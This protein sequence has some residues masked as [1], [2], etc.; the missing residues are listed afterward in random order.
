MKNSI[1]T[2]F[3]AAAA[4]AAL[5]SCAKDADLKVA[6]KAPAKG[7]KVNVI[8]DDVISKTYVEDG[9]VPVVKWSE[10]DQVVF[11]ESMDGEF[12]GY[13]YSDPATLNDG[14]ASFSTIL[15][16][17]AEEGSS[18]KYSAVYP[19]SAFV[20]YSDELY[21]YLPPEQTL[22]GN[23][24][25]ENSDILL[26]TM[27]DKGADRI[28]DGENIQFAFR[29]L[30]TVV[31][32][33]LNGIAP[34]EKIRRI[35]ISAPAYIAGTI[36]YEPQTGGVYPDT[37]FDLVGYDTITLNANDL[38]ATGSDVIWFRVLAERD[39]GEAGDELAFKVST[40]KNFYQKEFETCPVIRFVDGGLTKFSVDLSSSVVDPLEL[41]YLEDF[42]SG[43]PDWTFIDND[44]DGYNWFAVSGT[45][46]V[47]GTGSLLSYSYINNVGAVTPDN[48]AFTPPVQLTE[49]NYL[50]FYVRPSSA[51]WAAEH[52]AVYIAEGS[53]LAEPE[54]LMAE[55]E[56]PNGDYYELADDGM[57]ERFIIQ[58]PEKYNNKSVCIGFRHFNCTDQYYLLLDD[59][60]I[61]EDFPVKPC[62]AEYE[63]YLGEW[64]SGAKVFTV[65]EK[66]NGVSYSIS[67]LAGQNGA[68]IEALYKDNR[69]VL[70]EQ[71]VSSD[72]SGS[73]EV[74]LQGSDGNYPSYPG[75]D[76]LIIF[77]GE[78][79]DEE[80]VINIKSTGN[81]YYMFVTYV[82]QT[83][84]DYE[85][86]SLPSYLIPYVPDTAT[87]L[88]QDD[89][90]NGIDEWTLIDADGDGNNWM[91]KNAKTYSGEYVLISQSYDNT[92]GQLHPDNWAFT[93]PIELTSDNY[94]CFW[95]TAQD[96]N[97]PSEHYAVYI[98]ETAPTAENVDG[99][100]V[101]IPER[102]YPEGDPV[103]NWDNGYQR[104]VVKIPDT[105]DG[106]TVYIGFRHFN[107]TD[108]FW[109]NL[110]DVAIS[111]GNPVA[112]S[113]STTFKPMKAAAPKVQDCS[114]MKADKPM[115]SRAVIAD[116]CRVR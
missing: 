20:E 32:M 62:T 78:Y 4:A 61:T 66:V 1:I 31:R 87:Y 11:F 16:W 85:Y 82:D 34:G 95:I 17:E 90:E 105:Y 84:S 29:R 75:D 69:L 57:Y 28:A 81:K 15:D 2:F 7:I 79:D 38:E 35:E 18:Y 72:A 112:A 21:I 10:G 97:Y 54:V 115:P 36:I 51:S 68:A 55:T 113:A 6:D 71:L 47:S 58:I 108:W 77:K 65:E 114:L 83:R 89:F 80:D 102:I 100:A 43:A 14:K 50:S 12:K 98:T 8:T 5:V 96:Q 74:W 27:V 93:P 42:E 37:A 110:D 19:A 116:I 91:L 109:L 59:V 73:T 104:H 103:A 26:S 44:G 22:N 23:N 94:L 107:C 33:T 52:Y 45:Y 9:E 60:S 76:P 30:G 70:Y 111:E 49:D 63:D 99:C 101:L 46:T 13:A 86:D 3:F 64:A 41:P 56:Y 48:W 106:K 53:P 40:D 88:F 39:W 67:G 25:P 92:L 24:L